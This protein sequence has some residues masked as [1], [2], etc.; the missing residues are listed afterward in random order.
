MPKRQ[1]RSSFLYRR[2]MLRRLGCLSEA[3][4]AGYIQDCLREHERVLRGEDGLSTLAACSKAYD[5]GKGGGDMY[6]L[7]PLLAYRLDYEILKRARMRRTWRMSSPMSAG[8]ERAGWIC[9]DRRC[10]RL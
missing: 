1:G 5:R 6:G 3:E 8:R 4:F 10:H 7:M 2:A 9:L